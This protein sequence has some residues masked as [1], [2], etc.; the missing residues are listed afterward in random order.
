LER[1]ELLRKS[2]K[3][4]P[5]EVLE[6]TKKEENSDDVSTG[7]RVQFNSHLNHQKVEVQPQFKI[8]LHEN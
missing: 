5:N 6:S 2:V 4:N 3:Q 8:P 1:V 7:L